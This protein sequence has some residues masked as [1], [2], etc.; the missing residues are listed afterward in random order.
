MPFVDPIG[1]ILLSPR[2]GNAWGLMRHL[3]YNGDREFFRVPLGYVTDL[4]TVP[5]VLR[6]PTGLDPYGPYIRAAIVHD[7]LIT[8]AIPAREVTSRD[9]DGI[10]R[11]IMREEGVDRWTRWTMW[12]AVRWAALFNPRRAYGRGFLR[13]LPMVLAW[14]VPALVIA[15]AALLNLVTRGLL[16]PIQK[17]AGR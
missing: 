5:G 16:W 15:P 17:L 3:D 7:W 8:D 2:G 13:D 4:A 14:S 11:R 12:A 1:Y 9:A 10:F 6:S